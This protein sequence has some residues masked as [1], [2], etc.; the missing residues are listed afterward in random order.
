M[1][2]AITVKVTGTKELRRRLAKMNPQQN[3]E[4]F[5]RSARQAATLIA[6]DARRVQIRSGRGAVHPSR[7]THRSHWLRDHIAPDFRGFPR[8]AEVGTDVFYGAIHEFG[9]GHFPARPFM[10]P[11]LEAIRPKIPSIVVRNWKKVGGL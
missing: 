11:A 10:A 8:F 4:I 2:T 1:A 3:E 6:A 9:L 5:I 7:L